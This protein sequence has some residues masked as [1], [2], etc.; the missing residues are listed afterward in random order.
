MA[1]LSGVGQLKL[2]YFI[3]LRVQLG[4]ETNGVLTPFVV[5][6]DVDVFHDV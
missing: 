1:R 6:H 4:D 2:T 5:L 3:A